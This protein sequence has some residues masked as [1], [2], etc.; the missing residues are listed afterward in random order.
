MSVGPFPIIGVQLAD[1]E[2]CSKECLLR[3]FGIIAGGVRS[4]YFYET[5]SLFGTYKHQAS[6]YFMTYRCFYVNE[7]MSI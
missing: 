1:D 5:K 4:L 7:L 3:S 6:V 2:R